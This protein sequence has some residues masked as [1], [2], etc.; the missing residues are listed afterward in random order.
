MAKRTR[1]QRMLRATTAL[2]LGGSALQLSSC[3]PTVRS[4]LLTGLETTTSTLAQTF[5]SAF[6]VS[7]TNDNTS[8]TTTSTP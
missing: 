8:L 5:I 6:F 2:L 7:L 3:D 4:T 1:R